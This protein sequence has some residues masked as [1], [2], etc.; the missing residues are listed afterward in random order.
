VAPV[1]LPV[2]LRFGVSMPPCYRVVSFLSHFRQPQFGDWGF[3]LD[4]GEDMLRKW[5]M[6]PENTDI[7]ITHG[8][9][10]GKIF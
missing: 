6:I 5:N 3:N 4:R 8:P 7:L 2:L 1:V 9:P 10:V